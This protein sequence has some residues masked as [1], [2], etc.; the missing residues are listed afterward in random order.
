MSKYE[1]MQNKVFIIMMFNDGE[2]YRCNIDTMYK[3]L[4]T[5]KTDMHLSFMISKLIIRYRYNI[6]DIIDIDTTS[7]L[8][9]LEI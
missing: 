3:M 7:C 1:N 8:G 5:V 9:Q 6:V 2:I 4:N